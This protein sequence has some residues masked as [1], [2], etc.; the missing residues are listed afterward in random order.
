MQCP[1]VFAWEKSFQDRID[2]VRSRELHVLRKRCFAWLLQTLFFRA[3]P[4]AITVL[5]FTVH[6]KIL[7]KPLP[8]EVA[9]SSLA[10]FSSLR[11][12]LDTLPNMMAYVLSSLVS[13][14]RID[15]FLREDETLKY[16]QL[17]RQD[18]DF[19]SEHPYVGFTEKATFAFTDEDDKVEDG[20]AFALRDLDITFPTGQLS[21]VVGSVGSGKS[22]LLLSLL[23][24]TRQLRGKTWMPC[25][26]ARALV[27]TEEDGL[28]DTVAYCSQTPWLLGTS[29]KENILCGSPFDETR[30]KAVVKACALEP[31]L[32]ILEYADETE[33][34]EKGTS[35][36]GGQ[37]ARISLARAL[38][39][40]ARVLL[41]D[42]A[43]SALD[44]STSEYVYKNYLRGALV[45]GRTIVMV[46][47]AVSL[48]M[49]GAAFMV[50]LNDGKVI[51]SGSP[52]QVMQ[53]GALK[54]EGSIVLQAE[55]EEAD[56]EPTIEALNEGQ[57]K[58]EA[59]EL[60]KKMDKKAAHASEETI[61]KGAVSFKSYIFYFA[62]FAPN[63]IT[64]LVL[65]TSII[66]LFFAAKGADVSSAAWLRKWAASYD[67]PAEEIVG[68]L[69]ALALFP[70]S[71]LKAKDAVV[72]RAPAFS[73][74][75]FENSS[76]QQTLL[77][78]SGQLLFADNDSSSQTAGSVNYLAIYALISLG[79]VFLEI[80]KDGASLLGSVVASRR[81][82]K[83]LMQA[84]LNARPGFFD[85]TR[86]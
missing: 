28:S 7:G 6:T 17:L 38:Y 48:C 53:S 18:D 45:K 57:R 64:L 13:V 9:F 15:A 23:G 83:R 8:P 3:A 75:T 67:N 19:G 80:V 59:A 33:V 54:E 68:S 85:K 74:T 16:A 60:K 35:L 42:D 27:P 37:K 11:S 5:T 1:T 49:P 10:F 65:W 25:P 52:T 77:D 30:Y 29:V 31:D 61:A 2:V 34:G 21:I 81:I 72:V 4:I 55:K 78:P 39:S 40:T 70:L 86:E 26:V 46:T 22:T 24:E 14:R 63:P 43:L 76:S 36:S 62:N 32:K 20:S 51:A 69:R 82:Y 79:Y 58:A 41:I 73:G 12:A 44:A 56:A 50:A 84:I 47:H 66:L 71:I